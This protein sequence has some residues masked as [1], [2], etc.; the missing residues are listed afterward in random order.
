LAWKLLAD[1]AA[2]GLETSE[3]VSPPPPPM[4]LLLLLLLLPPPPPMLLLLL[5]DSGNCSQIQVTV[6]PTAP[7]PPFPCC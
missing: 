7:P 2:A 3:T 4:L 6:R 1:A 5:R